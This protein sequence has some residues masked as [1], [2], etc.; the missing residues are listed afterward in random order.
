MMGPVT[1]PN[2]GYELLAQKVEGVEY[3]AELHWTYAIPGITP[4]IKSGARSGALDAD[5]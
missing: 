1:M 3:L 5:V 4:P 2:L